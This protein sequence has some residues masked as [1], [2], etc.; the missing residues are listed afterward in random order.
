MSQTNCDCC[1]NP[2]V[3]PVSI[4]LTSIS[5]PTCGVNLN[6]DAG[7]LS[8]IGGDCCIGWS[9][10]EQWTG[11]AWVDG[12]KVYQKTVDCGALPN[13]TTK[14]IPH[15]II[16]IDAIVSYHAVSS[17]SANTIVLPYVN[18]SLNQMIQAFVSHN[19]NVGLRTWIDCSN[20]T[21][22]FVTILYTCTDR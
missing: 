18:S 12:K 8:G 6:I 13:A 10:E 16:N 11:R 3:S 4:P 7:A 15:G 2:P 5:L 20:Y 21:K 14:E 1:C 22:S 9:F 19:G 17:S